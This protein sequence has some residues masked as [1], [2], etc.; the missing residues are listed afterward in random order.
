MPGARWA[1]GSRAQPVLVRDVLVEVVRLARQGLNNQGA[2]AEAAYLDT[3]DLRLGGD[4]GC[5]ARRL[6][7]AWD[8]EMQRDPARLVDHLSRNTLRDAA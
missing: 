8:G 3:L 2:P 7:H 1:D 5:P 6:L 4:G